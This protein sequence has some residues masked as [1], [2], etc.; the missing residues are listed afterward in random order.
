MQRQTEKENML[1]ALKLE[2]EKQKRLERTKILKLILGEKMG[3]KKLRKMIGLMGQ[4]TL[5]DLEMEVEEVEAK[6]TELMETEEESR[7]SRVE[8]IF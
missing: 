7:E 6:V 8:D 4:L 5:E 3:A 2:E 1:S